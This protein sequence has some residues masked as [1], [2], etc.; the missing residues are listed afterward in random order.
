MLS[1]VSPEESDNFGSKYNEAE[2]QIVVSIVE[3]FVSVV[4][5][6]STANT[7]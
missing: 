6:Q 4:S 3:H 5:L 2:A 1:W 7:I